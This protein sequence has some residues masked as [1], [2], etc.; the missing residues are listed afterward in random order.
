MQNK[1]QELT[2][3]IFTEGVEKAR[4]EADVILTKAHTE[5]AQIIEAA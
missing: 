5:A 3:K 1:L 2:D 4:A